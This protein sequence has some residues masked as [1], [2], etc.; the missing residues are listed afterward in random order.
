MRCRNV[1]VCHLASIRTRALNG[2]YWTNS[3]QSWILARAGL[4]ADDPKRTFNEFTS[5][6]IECPELAKAVVT[7]GLRDRRR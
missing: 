2:R 7:S 3:G 4:S 5:G 1:C 6:H